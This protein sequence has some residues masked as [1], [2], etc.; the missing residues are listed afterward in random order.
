MNRSV[1][2]VFFFFV[3]FFAFTVTQRPRR[4]LHSACFVFANSPKPSDVQFN[5]LYMTKEKTATSHIYEK[6][7]QEHVCL[8]L[9]KKDRKDQFIVAA[10]IETTDKSPKKKKKPQKRREL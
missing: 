8:C 5:C 1:F 10:P 4:C 7:E 6:P 3:L 9:K 2:N